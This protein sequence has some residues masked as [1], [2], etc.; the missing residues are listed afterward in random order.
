MDKRYYHYQLFSDQ[1]WRD[2]EE[3]KAFEILQGQFGSVSPAIADMV[4]NESII[5]TKE[6]L[7]R[8]RMK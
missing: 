7:L 6:G 5:Q 8:I 1:D 4:M 3:S 2:I